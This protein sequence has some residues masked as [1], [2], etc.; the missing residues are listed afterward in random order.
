MG[1]KEV[2]PKEQNKSIQT[3]CGT[4]DEAL[5]KDKGKQ[6]KNYTGNQTAWRSLWLHCFLASRART[7]VL[8]ENVRER[9]REMRGSMQMLASQIRPDNQEWAQKYIKKLFYLFIHI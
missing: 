1:H 6:T 7:W 4:Q 2:M 9:E 3:F 5:S 8:R